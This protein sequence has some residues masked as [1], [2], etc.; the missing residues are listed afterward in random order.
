MNKINGKIIGIA[1]ALVLLTATFGS[2]SATIEEKNDISVSLGSLQYN[3]KSHHFQN[4]YIDEPELNTTVFEIWR[5]GGCCELSYRMEWDCDWV[6]VFPTSGTSHGEH[7][8]ITV[9]ID[10]TDLPLG[11][12]TCEIDIKSNEGNGVFTVHVNIVDI[13]EPTLAYTPEVNNLGDV[14]ENG[15]ASTVFEIWNLGM[16]ELIF[17]VDTDISWMTLSPVNGTSKGEPTEIT[18]NI[19][20]TELDFG[21]HSGEVNIQ[22]NG[23]DGVF[24]VEFTVVRCTELQVKP[25]SGIGISIEIENIGLSEATEVDYEISVVGGILN[26]INESNSSTIHSLPAGFKRVVKLPVFGLGKITVT[27]KVYDKVEI[28]EGIVF[29]N[30]VI[31]R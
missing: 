7:D 20:T 6:D 17:S 25:K 19:D 18:V 26:N 16:E 9:T 29:F 11:E 12:Y 23:G 5:G 27:T 2:L 15:I 21:E 4:K 8:E 3:P 28:F 13:K 30:F 24:T 14:V 31:I 22:S 10:T 1:T